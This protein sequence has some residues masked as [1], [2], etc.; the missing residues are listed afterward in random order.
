MSVPEGYLIVDS[1]GT[2]LVEDNTLVLTTN[3]IAPQLPWPPA[4]QEADAGVSS[5]RAAGP[6]LV[7]A[8]RNA[9]AL[10]VSAVASH[11]ARGRIACT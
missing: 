10:W 5:S 8:V 1:R 7:L 3:R 2:P 4:P 6:K 11:K 9:S